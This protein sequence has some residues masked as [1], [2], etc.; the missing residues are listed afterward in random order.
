VLGA[1][2]TKNQGKTRQGVS[3]AGFLPAQEP[4][5]LELDKESK[6]EDAHGETLEAANRGAMRILANNRSVHGTTVARMAWDTTTA[7]AA[8]S[9]TSIVVDY[10][11]WVQ[12]S[13]QDPMS[14]EAAINEEAPVRVYLAIMN[15]AKHL[16][17]LHHLR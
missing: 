9:W 10:A 12:A 5:D 8:P 7:E 3:A 14:P 13:R 2:S 11:A 6:A 1:W 16:L 4:Y 15:G 17:V